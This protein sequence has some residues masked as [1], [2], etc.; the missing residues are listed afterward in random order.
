MTW[1]EMAGVCVLWSLMRLD[2]KRQ[3][4]VVTLYYV[5]SGAELIRFRMLL[6]YP[7]RGVLS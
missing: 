4:G 2:E 6:G 3:V 5:A 7:V 1:M